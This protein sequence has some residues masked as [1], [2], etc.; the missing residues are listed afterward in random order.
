MSDTS[1]A[2][3]ARARLYEQAAYE[4]LEDTAEPDDLHH[5]FKDSALLDSKDVQVGPNCRQRV[6][7]VMIATSFGVGLDFCNALLSLGAC[8]LYVTETYMVPSGNPETKFEQTAETVISWIEISL[9]IFFAL[10]FGLRLFISEPWY[11]FFFTWNAGLDLLTI[12]PVFVTAFITATDS[13]TVTVL[14]ILALARVFRVLRI[15]RLY[16]TFEVSKG[17]VVFSVVVHRAP[18]GFHD[19]MPHCCFHPLAFHHPRSTLITK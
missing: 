13:N 10:D 4:A 19:F 7:H 12:I 2:S 11:A 8:F 18:N 15:V 5:V 16:R 14:S 3:E 9:S 17:A 1:E 6:Q